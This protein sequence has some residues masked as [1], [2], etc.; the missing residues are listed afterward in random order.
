[1][2]TEIILLDFENVQPTDLAL[3][4]GRRFLTRVFVGAT[5]TRIP[6]EVAYELQVLG[7]DAEY[8]RIQGTGHNALDFH[9]AYY[10]GCLSVEYPAAVFHII[11]RDT[12]F[13][14][15]IKHLKTRNITCHRW[16]SVSEIPGLTR[17]LAPPAPDRVR[18]VTDNLLR[19]GASKPR[20]LKS[21][22]TSI[23]SFLGNHVGEEETHEVLT[24][25]MKNGVVVVADGKV[26]YPAPADSPH[27]PG[28]APRAPAAKT[29][30][31]SEGKSLM[32]PAHPRQRKARQEDEE[33]G[34]HRRQQQLFTGNLD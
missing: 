22:V 2:K 24:R 20:K 1:M 18:K 9:I 31:D 21:L 13:D 19:L 23:K 33:P 4:R 16:P 27:H 26:S 29:A 30:A 11:S 15:L 17:P 5:Q 34:V 7:A 8:I 3:L 10:I 14:P 12:G 6:F 25:L 28:H 32:R